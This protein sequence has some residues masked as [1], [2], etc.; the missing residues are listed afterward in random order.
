[1]LVQIILIIFYLI[2][3]SGLSL[4]PL[5]AKLHVHQILKEE[6][7]QV[8]Y[9]LFNLHLMQHLVENGTDLV[10]EPV[11][12]EDQATQHLNRP[13]RK[14][15]F[16]DYTNSRK[17]FQLLD[18]VEV[19]IGCRVL[20]N[21]VTTATNTDTITVINEDTRLFFFFRPGSLDA[22]FPAPGPKPVPPGSPV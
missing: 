1:M 4:Q 10:L 18:Q 6:K 11:L 22:F 12:G 21:P 15:K 20:Q 3:D 2:W 14:N 13:R 19:A 16:H 9:D 5:L 8:R 7:Q 17:K